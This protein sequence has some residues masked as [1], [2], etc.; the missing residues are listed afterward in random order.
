MGDTADDENPLR[1]LIGFV[2]EDEFAE[3]R[4]AAN[5]FRVEMRGYENEEPAPSPA[6]MKKRLLEEEDDGSA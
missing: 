2:D 6:Q 4:L 5:E 1:N 3:V